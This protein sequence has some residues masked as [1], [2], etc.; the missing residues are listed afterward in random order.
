MPY[1]PQPLRLPPVLL[2]LLVCGCAASE[3]R[4][5]PVVSGAP[6]PRLAFLPLENLSADATAGD[7]LTRL[8]AAVA[9][10]TGTCEIVEAGEVDAAYREMRIRATGM[11]TRDQATQVARRLDA[12]WLMTGSILEYGTVRTSDGTLPSVGVT[13]RVLDGRNARVVWSAMDVAT[14]DD[15]ETIFGWGRE[16]SLDKLAEQTAHK[17]LDKL[18]LPADAGDSTAMGGRP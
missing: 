14:G 4:P 12:R 8:F 13:L 17:L 5:Q 10:G 15:R 18:R 11:L 1:R 6:L 9:A 16:A 7:K 3:P 2:A